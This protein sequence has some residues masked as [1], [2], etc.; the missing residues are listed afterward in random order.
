MAAGKMTREISATDRYVGQ[1]TL[2]MAGPSPRRQERN[3]HPRGPKSTLRLRRTTRA[4]SQM[5]MES[6]AASTIHLAAMPM[7]R[8]RPSARSEIMDALNERLWMWTRKRKYAARIRKIG[9][10]SIIPIRDWTKNMPSKQT[11]VAAAIA[12]RRFGQSRRAS[13]YIIGMH[14][15]PKI[16]PAIRQPNVL[17]PRSM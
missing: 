5:Q 9:K 15:V 13:R 3:G 12:K 10:M 1:N 14:K 4:T 16:E 11:S 6:H 8:T 2:D 7:A 17:L